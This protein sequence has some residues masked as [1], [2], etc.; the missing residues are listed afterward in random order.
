VTFEG[1]ISD[2][3]F[4]KR[5]AEMV[6]LLRDKLGGP[7]DVE[8]ACDGTDLYLLQ[9]RAQSHTEE[10]APSPIPRNLPREVVLFS[11]HRNISNGR[12]PDITHIVYID[13]DR[14]AELEELR[15]LQNVGRA[16]G[17]L[18][19]LLP[20]RQFVLMGPGRWG[21]R[22]DI[23]LGVHVTY[24]DISNTAVLMEI[25]RKKGQ[26]VPELSFGTHFF[27]DLVESDIRYI[28]LYPD[29]PEGFLD[30]TFMRRAKNLLAHM[31]PEFAELAD[32][33]HVIE[34]AG[35]DEARVLRVLMN[36]DLDEAVGIFDVPRA[37]SVEPS[38]SGDLLVEAPVEAHWRWRLRMVE[39]IA[40]DLEPDRFGVRAMY[41][42]GS[43][44]NAT[45]GPSSDIDLLIH[46][47]GAGR[48]REELSLWLDGWSRSLAEM[49]YLRTGYTSDGL[50]DVHYVT[51]ED[52]DKHTSFAAK[53]DA[54]TDAARPLRLHGRGADS[55]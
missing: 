26:Y 52:I 20:K 31:T 30:E 29:E 28:P 50:L 1:L 47:A 37:S 38:V 51:D 19:K 8:F 2:T 4:V 49:N 7:V 27:Q 3:P 6:T 11:A 48:R 55:S 18:N 16:V 36:A 43:V 25:A 14:Y 44:K 45:A 41:V 32:V 24:A 40:E 21:S 9:C 13:P 39:R 34:V 23:K 53:I 33:V 10:F 15:S 17:R 12:V 54:V 42:F 5:M 46:D 22:G 35:Q